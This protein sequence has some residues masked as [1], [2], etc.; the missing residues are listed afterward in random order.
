M[1]CSSV[2]INC[3]RPK[4]NGRK[5]TLVERSF[6]V[7]KGLLLTKKSKAENNIYYSLAFLS[8]VSAQ[9]TGIETHFLLAFFPSVERMFLTKIKGEKSIIL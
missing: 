6:P 4:D 7:F 9:K 8:I 2:F 5:R 3:F 1:F